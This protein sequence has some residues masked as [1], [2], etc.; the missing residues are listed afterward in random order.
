MELPSWSAAHGRAER[1]RADRDRPGLWRLIRSLPLPQAV[2][3]ARHLRL[4]ERQPPD[5][6]EQQLAQ[7]SRLGGRP[8]PGGGRDR[9]PRR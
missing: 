3:A 9:R 4:R 7:S 1:L 5:G 6:A 8:G 2:A